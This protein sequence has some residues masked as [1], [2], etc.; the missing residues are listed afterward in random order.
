MV[1][2][3]LKLVWQIILY[4]IS[5][6]E[7]LEAVLRSGGQKKPPN[8]HNHIYNITSKEPIHNFF[9]RKKIG[10]IFPTVPLMRCELTN[11]KP[12]SAKSYLF[13]T[14]TIHNI[15]NFRLLLCEDEGCPLGPVNILAM[16]LDSAA[17]GGPGNPTG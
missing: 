6:F 8:G 5:E 10:P 13:F 17:A 15:F 12:S 14:Q 11:R 2:F 1:P 4:K 7:L 9:P 3:F 16:L